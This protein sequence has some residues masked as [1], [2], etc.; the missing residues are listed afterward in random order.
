MPAQRAFFFRAEAQYRVA[1]PVIQRVRFQFDSE[2][3]PDFKGMPQHQIFCLRVDCGALPG[4]G[5][6]RRTNLDSAIGT[7]DVHEASTADHA[8]GASLDRCEYHRFAAFLLAQCFLTRCLKS[9]ARLHAVGNPMKDVI[10][11]VFGDVPELFRMF[12]ANGLQ[13]NNQSLQC[14]WSY[15]IQRGNRQT[16]RG[17]PF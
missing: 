7:I 1:R 13:T 2:A 3:L 5:D 17:I 16:H 6:P 9:S 11:R 4:W 14:D 8:S 15:D 12:V 10:E